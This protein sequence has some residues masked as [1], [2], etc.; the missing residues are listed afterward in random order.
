LK[1]DGDL[2]VDRRARMLG[3]LRESVVVKFVLAVAV[4]TAVAE[5]V[6]Y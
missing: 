4:E 3:P 6:A 5:V 2:L 1:E